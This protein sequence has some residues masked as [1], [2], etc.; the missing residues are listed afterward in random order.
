MEKPNDDSFERSMPWN[1]KL[2]SQSNLPLGFNP[3]HLLYNKS[4]RTTNKTHLVKS[5]PEDRQHVTNFERDC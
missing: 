4:I 5:R 1:F 3:L 2:C